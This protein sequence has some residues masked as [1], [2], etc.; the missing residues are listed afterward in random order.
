M[1]ITKICNKCKSQARISNEK[2]YDENLLTYENLY[3]LYIDEEMSMNKISRELNVPQS[4]IDKLLKKYKIPIRSRY[5]LHKQQRKYTNKNI[6]NKYNS[7]KSGAKERCYEFKL[8]IAE[9]ECLIKQSCHYC[10]TKKQKY[11]GIDRKDNSKGY[12]I[13]NCL[14]CC[15]ICNRAKNDMKYED[16]IDWIKLI[17]VNFSK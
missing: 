12:L 1:N 17:K 11:S 13:D 7:Y 2:K 9:F 6:C 3:R 8:T 16:F 4:K 15:S 10:G 14:P 5:E